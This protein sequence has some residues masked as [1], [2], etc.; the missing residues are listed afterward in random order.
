MSRAVSNVPC[1]VCRSRGGDTRGNNRVIYNDG[2]WHCFS[3]GDHR[4]GI[5]PNLLPEKLDERPSSS[6]PADFSREVPVRAWQWLFQFGLGF[7]HWQHYAGWS[8]KDSRLVL[9]VGTPVEFSIGRWLPTPDMERRVGTG[10]LKASPKWFIYGNCHRTP[11]VFGHGKGS[12]VV[13]V[14][15]LISAHKVGEVN[16]CIP[17]FG[18]RVFGSVL[19][20]LRFLHLPV[21]MWLDHDQLSNMPRRVDLLS[22]M[23]GLPVRYVSTKQDPKLLTFTEIKNVLRN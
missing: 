22:Q 9:T 10:E 4:S 19:P 13:L 11:H 3:C 16:T 7:K 8:E 20:C 5:G 2:G 1:P 12:S 15:D 23:T 17:L 14:E 21:V 6:T 18:T